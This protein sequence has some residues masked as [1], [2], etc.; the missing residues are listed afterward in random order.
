M[1]TIAILGAGNGGFA[2]A[3]H[4][5]ETGHKPQLYNRSKDTVA[6]IQSKGGI[7]YTGVMG[8]GFSE[9]PIISTSIE[10]ALD[11]ADVIMLT[12]PA[13]AFQDIAKTICSHVNNTPVILNPGATG[14]ALA[15]RSYLKSIDN[16]DIPPIAET[17]TLT[18]ICRKKSK[19]HVHITSIVENVRCGALD[20]TYNKN[21]TSIVQNLYPNI[22]PVESTLHSSL[23]NVNAILHPPGSILS[24][25]W[26]EHTAGDFTF[27]DEG[28]TQSVINIMEELDRERLQI[29]EAYGLDIMPFPELFSDIG[30]TAP[31]VKE[32]GSYR[33]ALK[34]SEPNRS[35]KAPQSTDHRFYHEDIPYGLVPM[36]TLA[37]IKSIEVPLINSLIHTASVMTN[38]DFEKIG[39]TE[40]ELLPFESHQSV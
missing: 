26:I 22:V 32:S 24:A 25:A 34:Q 16:Q 13:I 38:S 11:G 37:Q 18:Y 29:A 3:A 8:E 5:K 27:Y 4:L 39:W 14:G 20:Q 9:I 40:N 30:S 1:A 17:N 2:A 12:L 28:S 10:T 33:Q 35:I 19:S 15:F 31:E 21:I 6:E 36:S 23:C 7:E